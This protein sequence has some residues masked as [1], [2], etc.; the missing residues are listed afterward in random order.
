M[1]SQG[2]LKSFGCDILVIGHVMSGRMANCKVKIETQ[3]KRL[4][5]YKRPMRN[6]VARLKKDW[7]CYR[8]N[9]VSFEH[10]GKF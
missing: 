10:K 8:K 4:C 2:V 9:S 7:E 1:N 6:G 3:R 5:G